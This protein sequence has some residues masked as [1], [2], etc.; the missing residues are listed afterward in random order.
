MST[1][2]YL[3]VYVVCEAA[4]LSLSFNSRL[5][6]VD[7]HE[8][9]NGHAKKKHEK[10]ANR[11]KS[12]NVLSSFFS[13]L[14]RRFNQQ[15]AQQLSASNDQSSMTSSSDHEQKKN[16]KNGKKRPPMLP[17]EWMDSANGPVTD[18]SK[19]DVK[20]TPKVV[21]NAA[22]GKD[23]SKVSRASTSMAVSV[24]LNRMLSKQNS[25]N[26]GIPNTYIMV[27]G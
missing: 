25:P 11:R 26:A 8:P 1:Y 24:Q 21:R 4:D 12:A 7:G 2:Y 22:S 23:G 5:S 15:S 10:K 17:A 14:P 20:T 3:S 13:T 6:L 18:T 27:G 16:T 9:S 19:N